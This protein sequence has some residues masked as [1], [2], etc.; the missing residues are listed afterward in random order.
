MDLSN[1]MTYKGVGPF[2]PCDPVESNLTVR[3][4]M[5]RDVEGV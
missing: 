1:M 3:P 5:D 4:E 2:L